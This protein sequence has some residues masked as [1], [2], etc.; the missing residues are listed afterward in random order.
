[1]VKLIFNALYFKEYHEDNLI[2]ENN[3]NMSGG[4]FKSPNTSPTHQPKAPNRGAR[5]LD[6]NS[7]ITG[8]MANYNYNNNSNSK[9]LQ[10]NSNATGSMK[11]S[12]MNVLGAGVPVIKVSNENGDKPNNR[13][14]AND[15]DSNL[16]AR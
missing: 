1:M 4:L 9:A 7:A 6:R 11:Y 8:R 3:L 12:R 16:S 13:R 5:A 15:R 2:V 10:M 14:P